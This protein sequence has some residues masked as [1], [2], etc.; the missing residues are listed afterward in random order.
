MIKSMPEFAKLAS[1][2]VLLYVA[3]TFLEE[4]RGATCWC[5]HAA[6]KA[7][8][9]LV[10]AAGSLGNG[11]KAKVAAAGFFLSAAGDFFLAHDDLAK[12]A[13]VAGVESFLVGLLAFLASQ[14]CFVYCFN[15]GGKG[16]SKDSG[17]PRSALEL[18]LVT[19]CYAYAG[20][21][22][23]VFKPN[24]EQDMLVP[25]ALYN[26]SLSTMLAS[27]ISHYFDH[28]TR[29]GILGLLGGVSFVASDSYLAL[30][31]FLQPMPH[32]KFVILSTYFTAQILLAMTFAA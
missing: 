28:T 15:K 6:M 27:A 8:P 25:V 5:W 22:F 9:C 4:K 18:A 1:V 32:A 20:V 10:L 14:W 16:A 21:M 12:D 3:F 2:S 30:N 29:G 31:M 7:F 23:Q 24:L 19:A 11:C 17:E 13:N 26:V